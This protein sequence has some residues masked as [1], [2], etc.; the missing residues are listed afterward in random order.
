MLSLQRRLEQSLST[1]SNDKM[2]LYFY[3]NTCGCFDLARVVS[4]LVNSESQ[5]ADTQL[6]ED[7]YMYYM[8]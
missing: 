7:D 1:I 4:M 6:I 8:T 5:K 2:M 3:Y